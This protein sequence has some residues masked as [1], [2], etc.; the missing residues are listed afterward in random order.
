MTKHQI[1]HRRTNVVL[2][3][4]D[5]PDNIASGLRTRYTLEKAVEAKTY[6]GGAYLDGAYLGGANLGGA[7]LDGAYL[8]G[9][10]LG[11]AYLGGASLGGA[12]LGGAYLDGAYLG[13]ANLGGA[14]LG[15]AYLGGAYLG[16]A[17]LDGANLDGAYLGG[18]YLGGAY[19]DGAYLGGAYL[20]AASDEE[21]IA[22]LDKVGAII[23]DNQDRLNMGHWHPDDDAWKTRTCAEEVLC[24]TTHCLAGW[25]QV[26]S[27]DDKIRSLDPQLAGTLA[28]PVAAK[29]FFSSG[30]R[31][32]SWLKD[33]EYVGE[34][35]QQA[36][37]RAER[38]AAKGVQ[39]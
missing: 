18:A 29:M 36:Q 3:E 17:N 31:V 14:Y 24:E 37:R 21:S 19:L 38:E 2:F 27:T 34:L 33:R 6:L 28:A 5:V 13:G 9:A 20:K 26:C 30:E 22:A 10:S 4:C 25:L 12:Y 7:Y 39:S 16:G 35:A 32:L 8:G 23:L 15:G 11:G 1:K